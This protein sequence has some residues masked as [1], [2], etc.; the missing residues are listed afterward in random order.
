MA[1]GREERFSESLGREISKGILRGM[2]DFALYAFLA[3]SCVSMIWNALGLGMDDSDSSPWKRSGF[4]VRTDALTGRQYLESS[5]GFLT[6]RIGA[7]G[8]QIIVKP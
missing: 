8:Q 7:D 2:A 3:I 5:K 4:A 6:P 1:E